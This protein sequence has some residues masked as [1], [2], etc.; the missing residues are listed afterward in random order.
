MVWV[1]SVWNEQKPELNEF[2][3]SMY[4]KERL[5]VV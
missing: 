4:T 5:K 2:G 1:L 3:F